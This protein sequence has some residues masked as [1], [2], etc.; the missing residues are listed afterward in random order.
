MAGGGGPEL[1]LAGAS[2]EQDR[3]PAELG[4]GEVGAGGCVG[5]LNHAWG[6]GVG[7]LTVAGLPLRVR[8]VGTDSQVLVTPPPPELAAI[9][10]VPACD[11]PE[12]MDRGG[13]RGLP[14][15]AGSDW[16]LRQLHPYSS[17]PT[18]NL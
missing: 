1:A 4:R 10:A 18:P 7:I 15:P 12:R 3:R 5:A 13:G 11:D 6:A 2:A 9:F 14:W 17:P 16:L 8:D